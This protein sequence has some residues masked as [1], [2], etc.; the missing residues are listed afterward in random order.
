MI[1]KR[2]LR[3]KKAH[4]VHRIPM[5]RN[6][7]LLTLN[8]INKRCICTYTYLYFM[9]LPL[10]VCYQYPFIQWR[11]SVKQSS[12]SKETTQR[13]SQAFT[14]AAVS[15]SYFYSSVFNFSIALWCM[16]GHRDSFIKN[17]YSHSHNYYKSDHN[18]RNSLLFSFKQCT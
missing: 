13:Q 12:L 1:E 17:I 15:L 14:T 5:I 3:K 18:T 16:Q 6:S 10:K 11:E 9:Y 7:I 4:L 2:K 8:A